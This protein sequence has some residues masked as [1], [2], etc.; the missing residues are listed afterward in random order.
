MTKSAKSSK[1]KS[2]SSK[3]STKK[4]PSTMYPSASSPPTMYPST[5]S[6]STGPVPTLVPTMQGTGSSSAKLTPYTLF[7]SISQSRLPNDIEIEEVEKMTS[8]FIEAY[9]DQRFSDLVNMTTTMVDTRFNIGRPLEIDYQSNGFFTSPLP[10]PLSELDM[11]LEAAFN[12]N[13]L[14]M[15]TQMIR[16]LPSDNIF[17][18]TA[19]VSFQQNNDG[20]IATLPDGTRSSSLKKSTTGIVVASVSGALLLVL[21]GSLLAKGKRT[22]S[23]IRSHNSVVSDTSDF[24]SEQRECAESDVGDSEDPIGNREPDSLE[25]GE[26]IGDA[27]APP[28]VHANTGFRWEAP[29]TTGSLIQRAKESL[30]GEASMAESRTSGN[31]DETMRVVDL[32]KLFS[33]TSATGNSR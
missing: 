9:F 23:T 22:K 5:G 29:K 20:G 27:L 6:P 7:Y 17:S 24:L 16:D 28:S 12:G 32:I 15:Y 21:V 26:I 30:F 14:D 10:P 4:Y 8:D 1:S 2:S 3:K 13:S 33:A 19:A 25:S 11:I 18:T 31:S